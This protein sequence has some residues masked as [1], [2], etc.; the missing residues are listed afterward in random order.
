MVMGKNQA[1]VDII[2]PALNFKKNLMTY[3][4]RPVYQ[5]EKKG[6]FYVLKAFDYNNHQQRKHI[7]REILAL[8]LASEVEGI[9]NLVNSYGV[10]DNYIAIL[11]EYAEGNDFDCSSKSDIKLKPQLIQMIK[12]LHFIGMAKLDIKPGNTIVSLDKRQIKI[13]DLGHYVLKNEIS[14]EDFEKEKEWDIKSV[15]LFFGN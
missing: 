6:I 12:N 2:D 10:I 13:V 3:C 1:L 14:Q 4:E 5:V 11:K 8:G 7:Q 15:E 9:T